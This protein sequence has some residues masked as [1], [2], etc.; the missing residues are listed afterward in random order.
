MRKRRLQNVQAEMSELS[1]ADSEEDYLGKARHWADAVIEQAHRE[2][3][4][5]VEDAIVAAARKS[6]IPRSVLWALRYRPPKELGVRVF[7]QLK[8]AYRQ[9]LQRQ[10]AK[11]ELEIEVARHLPHTDARSGLIAESEAVLRSVR[12]ELAEL[13]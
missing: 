1:F 12:R 6:K 10:E 8:R 11:L 9:I 4:V 2:S 7:F 5:P 3:D 13:G